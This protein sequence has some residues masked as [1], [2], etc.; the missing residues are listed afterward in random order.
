LRGKIGNKPYAGSPVS[1][2]LDLMKDMVP[3]SKK[4][5]TKIIELADILKHLNSQIDQLNKKPE[6]SKVNLAFNNLIDENSQIRNTAFNN[7]TIDHILA[8]N[9]T[10]SGFEDHVKTS[11]TTQITSCEPIRRMLIQSHSMLCVHLVDAFNAVWM[12]ML[13]TL[14]LFVPMIMI[15]TSLSRMYQNIHPYK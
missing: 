6:S 15:T 8:M 11:M 10:I 9:K 4:L 3:K 12:S 2:V 13:V 7:A 14:V 5:T 1:N